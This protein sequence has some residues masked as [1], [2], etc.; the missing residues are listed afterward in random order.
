LEYV[1]ERAV[2]VTHATLWQALTDPAVINV[3]LR[4]GVKIFS[5]SPGEYRVSMKVS[6]GFMRPTVKADVRLGEI[7][8]T[9]GFALSISGKAMGA[10]VTGAGSVRLDAVAGISEV[11]LFAL[12]GSIETTGLLKKISDEKIHAATTDFL[13]NY[14]SS[15]ENAADI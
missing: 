7:R 4:N 11:T 6:V 12:S 14:F 5:D 8:E 13:E 1:Y 10:S 15:L 3:H 9:Q 2:K